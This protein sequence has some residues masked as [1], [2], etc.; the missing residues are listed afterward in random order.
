VS[1]QLP[2]PAS[3]LLISDVDDTVKITHVTSKVRAAGRG[4][5]RNAV[6]AG[7]AALYREL[8]TELVFVS[9]SPQSLE[10][11][12]RR[13]LIERG[14]FPEAKFVLRNWLRERDLAGFKRM[15]LQELANS[16]TQPLILV[17]DDSEKDPEL[18][19]ELA[20]NLPPERVSAIYIRQNLHRSLP[21]GVVP[22]TTAFELAVME[23]SAGRLTAEAALRVGEATLAGAGDGGRR[24]FPPFFVCPEGCAAQLFSNKLEPRLHALAQKLHE[25]TASIFKERQEEA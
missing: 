17:G 11:K 15:R 5:L 24:L 6:Y 23:M 2:C 4:L 14:G 25:L 1:P 19:L 13:S 3:H 20:N 7:M 9:G 12:L 8:A 10:S 16:S 22:F 18:F 21:Q